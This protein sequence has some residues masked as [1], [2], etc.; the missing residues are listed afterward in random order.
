MITGCCFSSTV[1]MQRRKVHMI[2]IQTDCKLKCFSWSSNYE[3]A[4][5]RPPKVLIELYVWF[6]I[7]NQTR[8]R[9]RKK[10]EGHAAPCKVCM[11]FF[12]RSPICIALRQILLPF[13]CVIL[14]ITAYGFTKLSKAGCCKSRTTVKC[15]VIVTRRPF[16][17]LSL[18]VTVTVVYCC[19]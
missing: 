18:T 2:K 14:L 15:Y 9:F 4:T 12:R 19:Q 3:I 16:N 17:F 13:N 8:H 5:P 10:M 11:I 1:A 6:L 7:S